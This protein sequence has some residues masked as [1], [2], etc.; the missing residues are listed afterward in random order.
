MHAKK[1]ENYEQDLDHKSDHLSVLSTHLKLWV[2]VC[3]HL[4]LLIYFS[5]VVIHVFIVACLSKCK[6]VCVCANAGCMC[7]ASLTCHHLEV[8]RTI[9]VTTLFLS[10]Q[11]LFVSLKTTYSDLVLYEKYFFCLFVC[12]K[13]HYTIAF[14]GMVRHRIKTLQIRTNKD[15]QWFKQK[16]MYEQLTHH[17]TIPSFTSGDEGKQSSQ[18]VINFELSTTSTSTFFTKHDDMAVYTMFNNTVFN[19]I[20]T[21]PN[22][23]K[24]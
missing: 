22:G 9:T 24:K 17:I 10:N 23:L 12:N 8:T 11:L 7:V 20:F 5:C 6:C 18:K 3:V 14:S 19:P 2:Y 4:Q 15:I 16:L 13:H 21:I 1:C